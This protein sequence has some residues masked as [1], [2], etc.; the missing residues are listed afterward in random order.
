[1]KR[2]KSIFLFGFGFVSLGGMCSAAVLPTQLAGAVYKNDFESVKVG[3]I[4]DEFLVLEGDFSV[5]SDG[6]N[7]FLELP[8][9][10]LE[11]F[12]VIFGPTE[13]DGF[14]VSARIYGTAKGRRMPTFAIGLNGVAGYRLRVS[15][16]KRVI[17]LYKRDDVVIS[18]PY[19]WES[20]KWLWLRLEIRKGNTE[21]WRVSGK[22]WIDGTTEPLEPA[23]SWKETEEPYAGR[24]SVWGSP[25]SG[26]PIR[27]DDFSVSRISQDP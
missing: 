16:A 19:Q 25:Y 26:M 11:S 21:E 20:G 5:K 6:T 12:G 7:K 27:F 15:A 23:F 17:E 2:L 13:K 4:P 8:G 22:V 18:V 24:A 9:A 10:P 1:M 3:G 14:S